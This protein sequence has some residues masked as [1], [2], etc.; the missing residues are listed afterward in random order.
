MVKRIDSQALGD[1]TLAIGLSGA[2]SPLTELTDGVVDQALV[3]NEIARRS[4]TQAG[5]SGIYTP[6][7]RS[8]NTD[9]EAVEVRID[10]YNVGGVAVV[11]PYPDP[12]PRGF[13]FWLLG[14]SIRRVSGTGTLLASIGIRVGTRNEGWGVDDGGA[15]ILVS[16]DLRL[17]YWDTIVTVGTAFAINAASGK[18][19]WRGALRLPRDVSTIVFSATSSLTS[20]YDCQL[21]AGLFPTALGQDGIG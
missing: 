20:T 5:T 9:A 3:V 12:V 1:L 21:I 18:P 13:D 8:V 14:A 19:H 17:F 4:Q 7:M 6:S 2:G 15:Q 16:Q 11:P 10:P